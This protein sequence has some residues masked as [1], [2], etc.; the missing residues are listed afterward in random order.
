MK[1]LDAGYISSARFLHLENVSQVSVAAA[2]LARDMG[3]KVVIDA[4][5]GRDAAPGDMKLVDVA[6]VSEFYYRAYFDGVPY[7]EACK[8]LLAMGPELIV[9][10]LGERGCV[11]MDR[12]GYFE[13]PAFRVPVADTTG[14]G[15]VFHGAFIAGL[16]KGW[17]VGESD[18][19]AS[20]AAA[21]KCTRIGGRAGIPD[22][23]TT[24]LFMKTGI[25]DYTEIDERVRFYSS[26]G[27]IY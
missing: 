3:V 5:S 20:A 17:S 26:S 14:A 25:I 18:R 16:L 21:I 9:F 2:R 19:F 11:G 24:M 27:L 15:D 22:L 1:S 13:I 7:E 12:D 10:T 8:R 23:K 4:D 6:V